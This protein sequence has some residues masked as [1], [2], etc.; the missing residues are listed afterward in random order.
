MREEKKTDNAGDLSVPLE[1][2]VIRK[3]EDLHTLELI[4][5]WDNYDDE[6]EEQEEFLCEEIHTELNRRG[7]GIHCVV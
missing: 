1:R 6:N 3:I 2:F 4:H 5:K 7:E